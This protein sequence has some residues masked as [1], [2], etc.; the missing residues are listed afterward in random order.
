LVILF[1]PWQ[2]RRQQQMQERPALARPL[3]KGV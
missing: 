1:R 3:L 2:M